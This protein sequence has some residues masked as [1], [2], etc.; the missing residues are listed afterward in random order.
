MFVGEAP[1]FHEDQQGVPFV[2]QAG[3]LL[4][5]LLNGI[6]LSRTDVYI[7]NV[8]K[9]RPPGNRDPQP[10]EIEACESHLFRQIELIQPALVATLGNFATKLLSGQAGRDH[11]RARDAAAG[12]ARRQRGHAL[13]AL[14]PGRRALHARRCSSVLEAGLR[15]DPRAARRRAAAGPERAGARAGARLELRPSRP[16]SSASSSPA[17]ELQ[18]VLARRRP[19][20]SPRGSPASSSPGDVVTVS[21]ELGVGK[22]T[23]VRGACRALGVT[24][25]VT[26]PTYT[27]GHRYEGEPGR[28]AP[29]PLPLR[30][31]LGRGVGATSSRTSRTPIVFVEWPE[32]A[33]AACRRCARP[34]G[35]ST[36]TS[37]TR[38][39]AIDG[40]VHLGRTDRTC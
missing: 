38:R 40:D 24:A 9:C 36:S 29:R 11:A 15:P 23:F 28:L 10:D 30:R 8:L 21:G 17:M 25:P 5:K 3:K 16:S 14:P 4:E 37:D 33:P 1:G 34:S 18:L 6:G 39:I 13:P 27:I 12:D 20:R 26:S 7:A 31:R 35:S 22:T 2:G 32:A 19:R